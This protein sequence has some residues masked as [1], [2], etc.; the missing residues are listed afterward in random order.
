MPVHA[1]HT[2]VWVD[3]FDF[4]GD[5]NGLDTA[6]ESAVI[7]TTTFQELGAVQMV[8]NA[9]GGITQRGYI[10]ALA[11]GNLEEA[12]QARLGSGAHMVAA[13]YGTDS[14]GCP[15]YVLP[16]TQALSMVVRSPVEGVLTV[17]GAWGP[18][19]GIRRGLRVHDDQVTATGAQPGVD[20][21]Q[22]GSAGGR[23]WLFARA[24]GGVASNAT[25]IVQSAS[26]SS[27]ASPTTRCTFSFSGLGA[28]AQPISGA[29]D[30][31]IRVNVTGMGG[32][33]S[34]TFG[35]IVAVNGVTQ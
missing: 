7:D 21:G 29:V 24:I 2:K 30:R 17:E 27:F 4:S 35:L 1:R 11:D 25:I 6:I 23:A 22:A 5:S 18:G 34:I 33:T 19:S 12:I 16:A 14:A 15:S 3:E 32:A 10:M 9:R 13:L 20:F 26:A 31:Y 8:M 28:Y